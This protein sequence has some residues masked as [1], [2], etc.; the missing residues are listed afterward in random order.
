M[1]TATLWVLLVIGCGDNSIA[2]LREQKPEPPDSN[3]PA[4]DIAELRSWYLIGNPATPGDDRV[5]IAVTA[6][7]D[8]DVVDA[9]VAD[10]PAVRLVEDAGRFVGEW[11]IDR[12]PAGTYDVLLAADG[13]QR[14]FAHLVFHRSA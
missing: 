11:P 14:A 8:V 6:P 3:D 13:S 12:L 4:F 1:R 7:S 10:F 9:W 5:R 2:P